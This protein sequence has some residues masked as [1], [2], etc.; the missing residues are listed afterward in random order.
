MPIVNNFLCFDLET[1]GF[2]IGTF[3]LIL[4]LLL[5]A[6]AGFRMMSVTDMSKK[7]YK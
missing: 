4:S 7:I 5:I 2:V 1:G 6:L 3:K